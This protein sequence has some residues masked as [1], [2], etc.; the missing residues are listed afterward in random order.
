MTTVF[1]GHDWA[2]DHHDIYIENGDGQRLHLGRL[3]DS[4][5][6]VAAFHALVAE[7]ANE[8]GDVLIA[9]ETDRGL[10]VTALIAAGYAVIAINPMSTSRYRERHSTSGAKSDQGDAAPSPRSH[11]SMVT[12]IDVSNPTAHSPTRSSSPRELIRV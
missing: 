12:T 6:G 4:V 1:I 5:D 3:D 10:F 7:H 9:S 11:A 2:E 8:P